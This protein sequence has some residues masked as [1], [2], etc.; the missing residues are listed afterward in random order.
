MKIKV[1]FKVLGKLFLEKKQTNKQTKNN[2][3]KNTTNNKNKK[4]L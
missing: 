1:K 4:Q 2:N 3:N